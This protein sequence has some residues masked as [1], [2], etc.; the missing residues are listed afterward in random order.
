MTR[1]LFL[2]ALL[3][4][5]AVAAYRSVVFV[6]EAETV[7]ITQFGD[8][9]RILNDT[10]RESGLHVKPPYQSAIRIDRRLQI[11]DPKPSEFLAKEKKNV[12]LDV[13]VCWRVESPRVF[14]ETVNNFDGAKALLHDIVWA[15]LAAEVGRNELEA[16]VSVEPDTHR[17]DELLGK[18]TEASR[19]RAKSAYGIGIVDVRLKRIALPSQV[20]ESVFNRMRAERQRIAGQYRAEGEEKALEIRAEADKEYQVTIAQA[21]AE[22]TKIRGEAEAEAIRI[23]TEAHQKDP[24]LYELVRSLEAYEKFLDDKTTV[25]L[26]A[27]SDL[28]KYLTRGS[29][30][31]EQP[32]ST[33]PEP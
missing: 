25:L 24:E 22:A 19:T 4:G 33:E 10:T 16:L 9:V 6:D 13:F 7:I 1:S 2:L 18:V 27:D 30:L 5:A 12:D 3:L 23:Y 29:M 14:L 21:E 20:R 8:P 32:P 11:Y 15:E 31:P 26:S 17:L 28:L